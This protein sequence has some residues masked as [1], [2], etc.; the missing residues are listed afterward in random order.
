MA[1]NSCKLEVTE[2]DNYEII[3]EVLNHSLGHK[4][5]DEN[6][7]GWIDETQEYQS[8]LVL[9]HT[10]LRETDIESIKGYLTFLEIPEFSIN[11]FKVKQK[12]DITKIKKFDRYELEVMGD[13]NVKSPYIG[14]IQI[15]S[16][17]YN[18]EFDE[19]IVYTSFLC[20][21]NGDCGEGLI[22]HLQKNEK[23]TIEKVD[24]LWV[25]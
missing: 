25:A 6:G 13:Q 23:W 5:D 21:G 20:A 18:D 12:W 15:S 4:S 9:N 10:N 7:L 8:L 3:S 22:F 2:T 14:M 16:I 17:S 19:A 11:D 1:F 24:V